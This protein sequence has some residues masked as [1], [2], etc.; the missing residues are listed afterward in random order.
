M[1]RKVRRY[2]FSALVIVILVYTQLCYLACGLELATHGKPICGI[3]LAVATL[4][5]SSEAIE[6]LWRYAK[7]R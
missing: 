6:F 5:L 1:S 3:V 7:R 4:W 2:T